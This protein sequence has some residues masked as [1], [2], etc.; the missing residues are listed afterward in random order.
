MFSGRIPGASENGT[1][2]V[3]FVQTEVDVSR[4]Y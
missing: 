4:A 1:D 3:M 2:N